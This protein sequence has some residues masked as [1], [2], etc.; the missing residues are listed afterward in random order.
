[1]KKVLIAT[2]MYNSTCNANYAISMIKLFQ[3]FKET[4][5]LKLDTL[6]ALNES[7]ITKTR[8]MI[9][10]AFMN[11]D[12]THLLF[13]DSDISFEPEEL[14]RMVNCDKD[15]T[16]GIYPKKNIDWH[17][18]YRAALR[19][20][21]PGRLSEFASTKLVIPTPGAEEDED[22]L[23]E[24]ERAATG[25]MLI[26]REV[27]EKLADSVNSFRLEDS[28]DNVSTAPDEQFKEYFLSGPDPDTGVYLHE[29]FNFCRMWR[30]IG[31]K[32]HAAPWVYLQH[33]GTHFFG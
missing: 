3:H 4:E 19:G 20:T 22:G 1:M 16:C 27:F 11:S 29:D 30:K 24:V 28:V 8:S 9:A 33:T 21:P 7:L 14:I 25:F 12:N 32:I 15:I 10:H 23:I 17:K 18:V 5:E 2:P 31:G 6:F 13:I 26:K